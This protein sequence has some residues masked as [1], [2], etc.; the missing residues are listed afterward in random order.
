MKVDGTRNGTLTTISRRVENARTT[1]QNIDQLMGSEQGQLMS[2]G[3]TEF[4]FAPCK[5]ETVQR[6]KT[7]P[8]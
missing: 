1:S 3:L 4:E 7:L 2:D 8:F 5:Y 6:Q